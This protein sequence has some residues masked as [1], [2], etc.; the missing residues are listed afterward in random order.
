[1]VTNEM[2]AKLHFF[3]KMIQ[4]W[5]DYLSS[6]P[7]IGKYL[8]STLLSFQSPYTGTI[9]MN[10]LKLKPGSCT[11]TVREW[12]LLHNPFKSIH[13]AAL[14]NMGEATGGLAILTLCEKTQKR[15]IPTNINIEFHKK[16]RGTITATSN[17]DLNAMNMVDGKGVL[18]VLTII[19]DSNGDMV[20]TVRAVWNVSDVIAKPTKKTL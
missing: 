11:T 16:A 1:M 15:S 18:D 9:S 17:V 20:A 4:E 8:F 3:F 14:L 6:I 10:V 19:I 7:L 5:F 2:N 12:W 13:A